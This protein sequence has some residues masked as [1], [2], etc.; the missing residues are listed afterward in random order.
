MHHALHVLAVDAELAALVCSDGDEDRLVP[1]VEQVVQREIRADR[2]PEADLH[3]S[4]HDRLDL[5]VEDVD[6]EAVSGDP[7]AKHSPGDVERLEDHGGVAHVRE[8]P[9]AG[10]P[11]RAGADDRDPPIGSP[12]RDLDAV[13]DRHAWRGRDAPL[14]CGLDLS[15]GE[16]PVQVSNRDRLVQLRPIARRFARM[17]ADP[18]ARGGERVSLP[19]QLE[20][21][22]ELPVGEQRDETLYVDPG[23]AG[24]SARREEALIDGESV[25]I[26]LRVRPVDR[27]SLRQPRIERVRCPYG[28]CLLAVATAGALVEVDVAWVLPNPGG[29]VP[30]LPLDRFELGERDQ[31]DVLVSPHLDEP[32][33]ERAHRAIVRREGLVE[34]RHHAADG[35]LPLQ[36]IRLESGVGQIQGRLHASDPGT[37]DE[38][39]TD[40]V[41]CCSSVEHDLLPGARQAAPQAQH[42]DV[43]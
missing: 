15:V 22:V 26:R 3:S 32:R 42:Q 17:V 14:A 19:I 4:C 16:E 12:L 41:V 24:V 21:L 33:S 2:R 39:R 43:G 35:R 37:D 10:E 38:Y 18:A 9:R 7:D 36:Q 23:G 8:V 27:L 29:E 31:L 30:R 5:V 11:G 40:L 28:T 6:R 20:G 25:R 13:D 34:L 1:L